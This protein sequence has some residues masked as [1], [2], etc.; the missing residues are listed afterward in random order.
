MFRHS[1]I[2]C[3]APLWCDLPDGL[4]GACALAS[5]GRTQIQLRTRLCNVLGGDQLARPV[6]DI[7]GVQPEHI[8]AVRRV[9]NEVGRS[10]VEAAVAGRGGAQSEISDHW[11]GEMRSHE[12]GEGQ[13][14]ANE[15]DQRR[16]HSWKNPPDDDAGC[17][18]E[19]KREGR[20]T[21]RDKSSFV[22]GAVDLRICPIE[23]TGPPGHHEAQ[24][25]R[26]RHAGRTDDGDLGHQP[27][28]ATDAL[29]PYEAERPGLE[30][31]GDQRGSPR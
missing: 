4:A 17:D 29:S 25:S 18:A 7:G 12:I 10:R 16:G 30:L 27:P 24:E 5:R 20:V 8:R 6:D 13:S 19:S 21:D 14:D 9:R 23:G 26:H 2:T 15:G 3:C 28:R 1:C 31:A 22:E 11:R